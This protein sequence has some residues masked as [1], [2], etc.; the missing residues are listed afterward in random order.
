MI[1]FGRFIEIG[2]RDINS[3]G[4][5]PM[6]QFDKNAS[7]SAIDILPL[8]TQRPS[9]VRKTFGAFM[10]LIAEKKLCGPQPLQVF[11]ISEIETAFRSFQNGRN[12]GKMVVEI[13]KNDKVPVRIHLIS[14]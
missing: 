13:R 1:Q 4:N 2:K 7:F 11:G 6:W 10:G 5:L 9:L 8:V 3:H 14:T 12:S